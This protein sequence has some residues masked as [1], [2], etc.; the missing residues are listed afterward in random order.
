MNRTKAAFRAIRET[1]GLTQG[2]VADALRVDVSSVKRWEREDVPHRPP[3]DAWEL[4]DRALAD[5]WSAVDQVVAQVKL[6]AVKAG[7]MPG[8]VTLP[9][10]RSQQQYDELGRDPGPFGVVNARSRA[11]ASKLRDMGVGVEWIAPE[12]RGAERL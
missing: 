2:D 8:A 11:I 5:H 12:D 7:A 10:W 1:V 3:A 9:Y 4:L 6:L